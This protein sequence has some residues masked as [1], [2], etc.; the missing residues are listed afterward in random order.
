[1]RS[2]NSGSASRAEAKASI[3]CCDVVLAL[4]LTVECLSDDLVTVLP[5]RVRALGESDDRCDLGERVVALLQIPVAGGEDHVGVEGGDRFE[6]E[7]G[8]G[9]EELVDRLHG[10]RRLRLVESVLLVVVEFVGVAGGLEGSDRDDSEGQRIVEITDGDDAF[11]RIFES[12][13]T[14]R[15]LEGERVFG[16]PA[17]CVDSDVG[18]SSFLPQP[19]SATRRME[20]VSAAAVRRTGRRR[21]REKDRIG[22]L[23]YG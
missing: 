1:M 23:G 11:R 19:A 10:A 16:R 18:E 14:V 15:C 17:V 4:F 22:A 7:I 2:A 12:G 21:R 6:V 3:G 13:R 9:V 20:A 8:V 5:R